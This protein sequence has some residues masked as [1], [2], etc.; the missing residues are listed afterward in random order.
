MNYKAY[1]ITKA[2]IQTSD[3]REIELKHPNSFQVD[4]SSDLPVDTTPIE[5]PQLPSFSISIP[6]STLRFKVGPFWM[7]PPPLDRVN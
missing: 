6:W 5:I 3:G 2:Y 1:S 7:S 4:M